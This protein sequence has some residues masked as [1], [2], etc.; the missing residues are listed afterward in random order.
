M[1]NAQK[2]VT[3]K[4]ANESL[5]IVLAMADLP[6]S[7]STSEADLLRQVVAFAN[8]GKAR[9]V[10]LDIMMSMQPEVAELL[11]KGGFELTVTVSDN[12][13]GAREHTQLRQDLS[14]VIQA[15]EGFL[16][17]E[18]ASRLMS[19]SRRMALVP[20]YESVRGELRTSYSFFPESLGAMLAYAVLLLR[21][22]ARPF[23][24]DFAR[25]KLERCQVYFYRSDRLDQTGR[26]GRDYC[27]PEHMTE[28]HR[29]TG[30]ERVRRT[31]DRVSATEL[32]P[33]LRQKIYEA[34]MQIVEIS[35]AEG[36]ESINVDARAA[37]HNFLSAARGV[38]SVAEDFAIG[39]RARR[40]FDSW[41]DDWE[42]K[43]SPDDRKLWDQ[44]HAERTAREHGTGAALI[45]H[46]VLLP[47]DAYQ[48]S[49]FLFG[50]HAPDRRSKPGVRFEAYAEKRASEVCR[51]YLEL[52]SRFVDD[53]L[54]DHAAD[55][56]A[57]K[58]KS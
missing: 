53:Y 52:C 18:T 19:S 4:E 7:G 22:K 5:A 16:S 51:S 24:E 27:C 38:H 23:R 41:R 3:V 58:Q 10:V 35:K 14:E 49:S 40:A 30:A 44:M 34:S 36:T 11:R 46:S 1:D 43:L 6:R 54:R 26:S 20:R 57:R 32:E 48:G 31:R 12:S 9:G 50:L 47:S 45:G 29:Q 13:D 8:D 55:I 21:D 33:T 17:P 39:T 28:R 37:V 42:N 25:C 56:A 15:G 2:M